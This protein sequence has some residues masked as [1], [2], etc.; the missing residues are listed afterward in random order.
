MLIKK[1][2][3]IALIIALLLGCFVSFFYLGEKYSKPES[4]K[5]TIQILDKKKENVLG[6]VASSTTLSAT[7]SLLP[8]DAGT[9]IA[10]Q[11]ADLSS[12]L[13]I[14]LSILY[15]EKYLLTVIG[16][17]VFK[18]LIPVALIAI[19]INLFWNNFSLRKIIGKI[20]AASVVLMLI[21][22]VSAKVTNMID[23]TYQT[24][25]LE[26]VSDM[27]EEV[28]EDPEPETDSNDTQTGE[29]KPWY[30]VVADYISNAVDSVV[31]AASTATSA[32]TNYA[33]DI[34]EKARNTLNNFIEATAV[35]LVTS[36]VIPIVTFFAF[37]WLMKLILELDIPN[38]DLRYMKEKVKGSMKKTIDN[39]NSAISGEQ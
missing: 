1:Y 34:I 35:M 4:Y 6:L 16:Y 2:Y 24:S 31:N 9:P 27:V 38:P 36:C 3:K 13:L 37:T 19:G 7:L 39:V 28:G 29:K 18:V 15:T 21:V 22:P 17:A 11:F 14:I 12:Y 30:S 33:K 8:G 32:V 25:L 10:Q 23:E 5:K 26:N 20:V